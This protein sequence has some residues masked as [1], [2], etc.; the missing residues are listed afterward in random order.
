MPINGRN[1]S[2]CLAP[3]THEKS[4]CILPAHFDGSFD[5]IAKMYTDAFLWLL[6]LKY[7]RSMPFFSNIRFIARG[8]N[9]Q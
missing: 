3:A 7:S 9:R 5:A 2:S 4:L 6:K 1:P 8:E